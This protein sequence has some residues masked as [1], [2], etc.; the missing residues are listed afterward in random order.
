M[1]LE[2][3]VFRRIHS[4]QL[5][6]MSTV[7]GGK[8]KLTSLLVSEISL[9]ALPLPLRMGRRCGGSKGCG[10]IGIIGLTKVVVLVVADKGNAAG[11]DR[12][13]EVTVFCNK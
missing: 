13:N 7:G 3:R 12:D 11:T 5:C 8:A 10:K 9:L 4:V 2:H 1:T 6:G